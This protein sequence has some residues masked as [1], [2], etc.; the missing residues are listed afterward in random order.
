MTSRAAGSGTKPYVG[1]DL[2]FCE[3]RLTSQILHGLWGL[4]IPLP[5]PKSSDPTPLQCSLSS[6]GPG[7]YKHSSVYSLFSPRI[8]SSYSLYLGLS[9]F[10]RLL[11]VPPHNLDSSSRDT[12]ALPH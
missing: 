10:L 6:E 9:I 12:V 3:N 1:S 2:E 8:L 5:Y 4:L 11:K 7:L